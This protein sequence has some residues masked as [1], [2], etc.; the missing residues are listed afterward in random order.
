VCVAF[1]DPQRVYQKLKE[2]RIF[3]DVRPAY[4][5]RFSPHVYTDADDID[6]AIA[7]FEAA[8]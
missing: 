2:E 7:A 1:R 4:G 5:V 8:S 3:V 6:H